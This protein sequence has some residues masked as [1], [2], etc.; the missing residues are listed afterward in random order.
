M[1]SIAKVDSK[2]FYRLIYFYSKTKNS[3]EIKF[4]SNKTRPLIITSMFRNAIMDRL[5]RKK[6]VPNWPRTRSAI[7][8]YI[9]QCFK[10]IFFEYL[11]KFTYFIQCWLSTCLINLMTRYTL[12]GHARFSTLFWTA[13]TTI[14]FIYSFNWFF[15]DATK[16]W[17]SKKNSCARVC[18]INFWLI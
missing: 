10:R 11:I 4:S 15:Q 13:H 16:S 18:T 5:S 6:P 2:Y 8:R 12:S 7:L 9:F 17:I 14:P 3:S 1:K